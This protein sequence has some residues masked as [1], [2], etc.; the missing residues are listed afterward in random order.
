M[1]SK[2]FSIV[3]GV[4]SYDWGKIGSKSK[5]AQF[6][7]KGGIPNFT[8]DNFKPYAELWMGTHPTVPSHLASTNETLSSYI[9]SSPESLIGPNVLN[10][11]P[12]A[13]KGNL[14]FLFKILA[15]GKALSIQAHPHKELAEKLHAERPDLYKDPNH[16]PEMAIAL[17]PFTALC[18]FRPP[19][20]IATFLSV[21]P[22]FASLIPPTILTSF[23]AVSSLPPS[24]PE[25]KAA[26]RDVFAALMT[27]PAEEVKNRLSMLVGRYKSG[28]W[29]EEEEDVKDWAV[30]LDE[31]FPSDIG[32]FCVYVLNIVKLKPGEAIFLGAGEPHA[33]LEGDIVETM[34]TSDN[35]L[36]AGLTPKVRD[37]P[38]LVSSLTYTAA[39][40]SHHIVYPTASPKSPNTLI[41]DPPIPEFVVSKTNL[42][43]GDTDALESVEGPSIAIVTGGS[44]KIGELDVA[45]G[46]VV[47][48]GAGEEV[49]VQAGNAGLEV[50]RAFVEA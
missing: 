13:Q 9:A 31:Q 33:Y 28:G 41:Y 6:A 3:G 45:E 40:P 44:A 18:G 1:T 34:A 32:V 5:A 17:T 14:P 4:Q 39:D 29:V 19:P 37:V 7:S 49:A 43:G 48:V 47:F 30:K 15:I 25:L 12:S 11:F 22:E 10:A 36:R 8:I 26:L 46:S 35:V 21:V 23:Q 24:N 2:V 20:Q 38:N 16:K 50:F 42:G 27:A